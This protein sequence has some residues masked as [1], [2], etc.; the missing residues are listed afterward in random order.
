MSVIWGC[1]KFSLDSA[2]CR[3]VVIGLALWL[4][5]TAPVPAVAADEGQSVAGQETET[6]GTD[7]KAP[8]AAGSQSTSG[9]S[10]ELPGRVSIYDLQFGAA[11]FKDNQWQFLGN[12]RRFSLA[13]FGKRLTLMIRFSYA[14]SRADIPLKFIIKLPDSR[15]YE[16]TVH[17]SSRRGQYVYRFTVHRPSDF[18]G[19]GSVYLYYGFSIVDVLDF[20]ILP[21]A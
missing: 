16:E 2:V 6:Q 3:C 8:P 4:A 19:S 9:L 12:T 17:L 18:L 21:G 1:V 5:V 13:R 15:Q 10:W 11:V 14:G 7:A 20:S